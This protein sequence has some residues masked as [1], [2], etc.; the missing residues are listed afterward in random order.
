MFAYLRQLFGAIALLTILPVPSPG[1]RQTGDGARQVEL[2]PLAGGII[3]GIVLSID[4]AAG[5]VFSTPVRSA[6]VVAALAIVTGGLHLDGLADTFDGICSRKDR[7]TILGIMRDSR[8]GAM[9]ATALVMAL[10]LKFALLLELGDDV[11]TEAIFFMAVAGRQAMVA[12]IALYG[13]ARKEEGLGRRYA[14]EGG[15]RQMRASLL[16]TACLLAIWALI[17]AGDLVRITA[18]FISILGALLAACGFSRGVAL[19]IGGMTGDVYGAVN[20]IAEISFLLLF[21]AI[22]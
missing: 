14:E 12:A 16:L 11:R 6:A 2:F 4:V 17:R 20:E 7:E 13:Y 1:G 19:R 10:L 3:G 18:V 5:Q 15:V 21:A 22:T 8:I 9:G